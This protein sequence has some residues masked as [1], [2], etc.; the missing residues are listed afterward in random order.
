MPTINKTVVALVATSVVIWVV[1][2]KISKRKRL[3]PGPPLLVGNTLEVP[4]VRPWLTYSAW[5]N[6]YGMHTDHSYHALRSMRLTAL[7][8]TS[9]TSKLLVGI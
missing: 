5:A 1:N 8:V 6:Q 2:R 9:S 3:P 4:R 7:Q